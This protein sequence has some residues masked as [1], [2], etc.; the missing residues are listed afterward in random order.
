MRAP[1][2]LWHGRAHGPSAGSSAMSS[3]Q[4][5]AIILAVAIGLGITIRFVWKGYKIAR[6]AP[7]ISSYDG[8]EK[9]PFKIPKP[10]TLPTNTRIYS[11]PKEGVV[12]KLTP[13]QTPDTMIK[14]LGPSVLR[15]VANDA[16]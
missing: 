9:K 7:G 3:N 12:V 5:R 1:V 2:A 14:R 11:P 13:I 6:S 16:K 8:D 15:I 10:N 4:L